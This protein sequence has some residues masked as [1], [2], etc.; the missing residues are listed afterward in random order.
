[1]AI[2]VRVLESPNAAKPISVTPLGIVILDAEVMKKQFDRISVTL[3][4]SISFG[5]KI[6]SSFP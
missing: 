3:K 5:I 1:M 6:L 4:P 2:L